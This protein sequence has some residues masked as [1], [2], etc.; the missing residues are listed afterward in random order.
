MA[1]LSILSHNLTPDQTR[2]I[3][4]RGWGVI[5]SIE[6]VDPWLAGQIRQCPSDILQLEKIVNELWKILWDAEAS[7]FRYDSLI[8]PG[9]SPAFMALLCKKIAKWEQDS[10][11]TITLMFSDTARESRDEPQPDGSIEKVSVFKHRG[12]ILV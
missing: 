10:G 5:E 12:W 8:A 2:T 1:I 3:P 4:F 6:T 11:E 7:A 9:G